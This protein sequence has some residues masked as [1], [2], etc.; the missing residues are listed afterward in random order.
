MIHAKTID[1]KYSLSSLWCSLVRGGLAYVLL[2]VLYSII[3]SSSSLCL[4]H[5]YYTGNFQGAYALSLKEHPFSKIFL[6]FIFK[7]MNE[8]EMINTTKKKKVE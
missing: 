7:K 2:L 4:T 1:N 5:T 6:L 3:S 8:L